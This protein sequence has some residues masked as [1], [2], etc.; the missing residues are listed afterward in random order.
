MVQ[1][2]KNP[3]GAESDITSKDAQFEAGKNKKKRE[4]LDLANAGLIFIA[5]LLFALI[6]F[7]TCKNIL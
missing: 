1:V 3:G 2:K 7:L 4:K 5:V 6:V